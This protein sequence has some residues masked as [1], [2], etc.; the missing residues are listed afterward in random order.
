MRRVLLV[1]LAQSAVTL[2]NPQRRVGRRALLCGAAAT[3]CVQPATI[4]MAKDDD[5][6]EG[7]L[8]RAKRNAL[9]TDNV[10]YRAVTDTLVDPSRIDGCEV[11]DKI[12]KIDIKAAEEAQRTNEAMLK[13]ASAAS[14]SDRRSLEGNDPKVLREGYSIGRLVE[15]R[16]RER[17]SLINV[18]LARQCGDK[19]AESRFERGDRR[20]REGRDGQRGDYRDPFGIAG[21]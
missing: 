19:E 11:L 20:N 7:V 21:Y 13:L 15:E 3:A 14:D 8:D 17:A 1:V 12:Y 9:T 4:A 5:L 2:R 10:L 18:K 16:I 6:Y